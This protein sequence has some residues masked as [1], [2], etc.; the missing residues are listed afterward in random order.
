MVIAYRDALPYETRND[1]HKMCPAAPP[2]VTVPAAMT[3]VKA[4]KTLNARRSAT[5][6]KQVVFKLKARCHA[7]QRC[8]GRRPPPQQPAGP[9]W[10]APATSKAR[11]RLGRRERFENPT[12]YTNAGLRQRLRAQRR[13]PGLRAE[14]RAAARAA[15]SSAG[16]ARE[17]PADER[18]VVA[19]THGDRERIQ[20]LLADRD[21]ARAAGHPRVAAATDTIR[22]HR[23]K[24]LY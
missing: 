1:D 24:T 6:Q 19:E 8:G 13:G 4:A 15:R 10:A 18:A 17:E 12:L 23:T 7:A 2:I 9:R 21:E 14:L 16:V 5:K 20:A 11:V 3:E 22:S